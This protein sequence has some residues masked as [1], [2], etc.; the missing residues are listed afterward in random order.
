MEL[1]D[2]A[3]NGFSTQILLKIITGA[4]FRIN[5]AAGGAK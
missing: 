2:L 4:A 1:P 5:T 3:I